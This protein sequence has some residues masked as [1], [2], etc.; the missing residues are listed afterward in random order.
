[1]KGFK[2][3]QRWICAVLLCAVL[4][5]VSFFSIFILTEGPGHKCDGEHCPVCVAVQHAERML[6]EIGGGVFGAV[7]T[8][9]SFWLPVRLTAAFSGRLFTAT[10]VDQKVRMNN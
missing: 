5:F 4:F 2:K 7:L 8:V 9:L 6:E 3:E 1:M 10:L